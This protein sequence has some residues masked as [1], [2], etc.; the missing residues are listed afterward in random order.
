[1]TSVYG[2]Q[3]RYTPVG[4]N[5]GWTL[6]HISVNGIDGGWGYPKPMI[7]PDDWRQSLIWQPDE[8]TTLDCWVDCRRG[9]AFL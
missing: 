8:F 1:M 7:I 5:R 4:L 2:I 3:R 9:K 6:P